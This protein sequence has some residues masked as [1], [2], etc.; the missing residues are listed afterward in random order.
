MDTALLLSLNSNDVTD[1]IAYLKECQNASTRIHVYLF[2]GPQLNQETR[3]SLVTAI[4]G[5]MAVTI[6]TITGNS[7]YEFLSEIG[8]KQYKYFVKLT[9]RNEADWRQLSYNAIR[10]LDKILQ[11][12]DQQEQIGLVGDPLCSLQ[13]QLNFNWDVYGKIERFCREQSIKWPH[14][15][16]DRA[17]IDFSTM[18][19]KINGNLPLEYRPD[20]THG[21]FVAGSILVTRFDI[22]KL[23]TLVPEELRQE[24]IL[25]RLYGVFV[26]AAGKWA[27][28]SVVIDQPD[29]MKVLVL[30]QSKNE[31]LI[32]QLPIHPGITYQLVSPI[33]TGIFEF[34]KSIKTSA[35]YILCIDETDI[36]HPQRLMSI[37]AN[38]P[39]TKVY[40]NSYLDDDFLISN[41]VIQ[42]IRDRRYNLT[43][44][45][46]DK[47]NVTNLAMIPTDHFLFSLREHMELYQDLL[48]QFSH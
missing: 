21:N 11:A 1:Y 46:L 42:S 47:H 48:H 26:A 34:I 4:S 36:V 45:I 43:H 20:R 37:I 31:K 6:R 41:D 17:L 38:L 22:L 15:N 33:D 16:T 25:E 27:V 32:S 23:F 9:D 28:P 3:L 40:M 39:R 8:T 35:E 2:L 29:N 12:L 30:I 18:R 14:A 19:Y 24:P 13:E 7:L 5:F 10:P 44:M